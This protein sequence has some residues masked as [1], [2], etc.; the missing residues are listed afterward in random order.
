MSNIWVSFIGS[1]YHLSGPAR[2]ELAQPLSHRLGLAGCEL[3]LF[4]NSAIEAIFQATQGMPRK[5]TS[6]P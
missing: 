6:Q 1:P 5:V 2:E 4:E 3:P